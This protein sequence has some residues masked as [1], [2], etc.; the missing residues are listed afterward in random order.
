VYTKTTFGELNGGDMFIEFPIDGDNH[1]HGGHRGIHYIFIK[2][3][4]S[5]NPTALKFCT[6]T[7]N[8]FSDDFEVVQVK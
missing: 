5:K 7:I 8:T 3:G 1:G 4:F 6:G 2:I